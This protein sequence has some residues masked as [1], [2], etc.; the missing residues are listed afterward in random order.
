[1]CSRFCSTPDFN[2]SGRLGERQLFNNLDCQC[3]GLRRPPARRLLSACTSSAAARLQLR[4]WCSTAAHEH[5]MLEV[6]VRIPAPAPSSSASA[7]RRCCPVLPDEDSMHLWGSGLTHL[8]V[9]EAP[10]RL[11]TFK[12]LPGAPITGPCTRVQPCLASTAGGERYSDGPPVDG[13][14]LESAEHRTLNPRGQGASPWRPTIFLAQGRKQW[15]AP[16]VSSGSRA[17]LMSGG[18]ASGAPDGRRDRRTAP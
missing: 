4:A 5:A 7:C 6:R 9:N 18:P 17:G 11:R 10:K 16:C 8:A 15:T 1:M 2:G 12:S 14:E 3:A 13:R